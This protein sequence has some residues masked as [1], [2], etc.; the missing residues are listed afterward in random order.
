MFI[1][2]ICYVIFNIRTREFK[3]FFTKDG[4]G[5]G[6]IAVFFSNLLKIRFIP[7]RNFSRWRRRG[8]SQTSTSTS[9]R[10]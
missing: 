4:G 9:T 3:K 6:S 8:A 10:R 2:G 1:A 5:I 7:A